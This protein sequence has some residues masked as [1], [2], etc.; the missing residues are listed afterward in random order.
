MVSLLVSRKVWIYLSS[1][2]NIRFCTMDFIVHQSEVISTI[3]SLV[4]FV[5][6]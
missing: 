4:L 1:W 6:V 3:L 5:I 2:V